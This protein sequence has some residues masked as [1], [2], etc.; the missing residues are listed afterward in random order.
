VRAERLHQVLHC[1]P[2]HEWRGRRIHIPL[3][4]RRQA[5]ADSGGV[6]VVERPR[7][8][9]Q[10]LTDLGAIAQPAEGPLVLVELVHHSPFSDVP[11]RMASVLAHVGS[12]V[13]ER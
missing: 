2:S 13:Q 7:Q 1:G 12:V 5:P 6:G 8:P 11:A 3:A 9:G 10:P 4:G